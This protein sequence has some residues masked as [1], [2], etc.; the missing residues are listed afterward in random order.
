MCRRRLIL[1]TDWHEDDIDNEYLLLMMD[2]DMDQQKMPFVDDL[3]LDSLEG[4]E[5]QLVHIYFLPGQ[6][7]QTDWMK[8]RKVRRSCSL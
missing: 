5:L 3:L 8:A 2:N 4:F 1:D 6:L 7:N